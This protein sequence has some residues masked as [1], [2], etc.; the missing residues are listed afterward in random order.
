MT[1][2]FIHMMM[3]H[4]LVMLTVCSDRE[5]VSYGLSFHD[6]SALIKS[7]FFAE[8][9]LRITKYIIF[10]CVEFVTYVVAVCDSEL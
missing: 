9:F 6:A 10:I 1:A 7:L 5:M 2:A 3:C 8:T 4:V